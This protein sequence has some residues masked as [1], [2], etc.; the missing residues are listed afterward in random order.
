MRRLLQSWRRGHLIAA[1]L[2]SLAGTGCGSP[3]PGIAWLPD[4]SGFIYTGGKNY[5]RLIHRDLTASTSS[6]LVKDTKSNTVWPAVSPDGRRVAVARVLRE[7]AQTG[8][9]QVVIY[10]RQGKEVQH[11]Q[12]FAWPRATLGGR[13]E[14]THS[15]VFWSPQGDKLIVYGDHMTGL[16]DVGKDELRK[17]PERIPQ[18]FENTPIRPDGKGFLVAHL[19]ANIPPE[20]GPLGITFID[21]QGREKP[22]VLGK[23]EQDPERPDGPLLDMRP[24]PSLFGS[25]WEGNVAIFTFA[26]SRLRID[27]LSGVA[28]FHTV[29]QA[30]LTIK[31]AAI[32]QQ[33]EFPQRAAKILVLDD[34][35]VVLVAGEDNP[36]MVLDERARLMGPAP[37]KQLVAL[38]TPMCEENG[39]EL[40][41]KIIVVNNKAEVVARVSVGR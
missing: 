22:I 5:E 3:L 36:R 1:A 2:L 29:G 7:S 25:R 26:T 20:G 33:Y 37:N 39:R 11:S 35:V 24:L 9:L 14:A 28:T 32:L 27:S 8:T 16:Y 13:T 18:V 38:H 34:K 10:D 30:E 6:V 15:Q 40:P 21:W 19:G 17:W 23:S 41:A 12:V 31:G 4:S